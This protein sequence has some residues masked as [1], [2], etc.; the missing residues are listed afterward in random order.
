MTTSKN[1]A[2][3][4][5]LV[6]GDPHARPDV[7]NRRFSLLG[8]F[9]VDKKPDIIVC[10]GDFADMGSLSSYDKGTVKAEGKRYADDL[11]AVHNALQRI[12]DEIDAYNKG[13]RKNQR[14]EPR[15]CMV[16]GNHEERIARAANENPSL[17]GHISFDD[18][19][20]E[21]FGWEV[22]PFLETLSI[23]NIAFQHYFTSGVMGKPI[24]G[25]Y[26]ASHLVKKNYMS[27]VAGHSHLRQY[28]ETSDISGR[29]RFGLV[30]GC[31]DEGDHSYARG[32]AHQ[33]WSGLTML[34]E[35]QD[36]QCEPAFFSLD[37]LMS[38]YM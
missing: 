23:H 10:I 36:G 17:Y 29:K 34:H 32:T 25:D 27:C 22:T 33:W 12:N 20:Y 14:Y 24:S 13:K 30:V 11:K 1:K 5:I 26:A 4:K 7:S 35:V 6:I 28:W 16:M 3:P 9:I 31:F 2:L 38:R 37:Y 19:K 18:L 15:K 21:E 8:K